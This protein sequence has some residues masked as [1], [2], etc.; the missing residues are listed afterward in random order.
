MAW[1]EGLGFEGL[2]LQGSGLESQKQMLKGSNVKVLVGQVRVERF[3]CF[4]K[5]C[6]VA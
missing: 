2:A 6:R 1:V 5:F 3:T 4:P